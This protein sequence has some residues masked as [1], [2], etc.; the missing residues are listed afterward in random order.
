MLSQCSFHLY[1]PLVVAAP[2][3]NLRK[4]S[5]KSQRIYKFDFNSIPNVTYYVHMDNRT[6]ISNNLLNFDCV[7]ET[8]RKDTHQT[9]Q[10][11]D[12]QNRSNLLDT[13]MFCSAVF[14][15]KNISLL[16]A[17][18]IQTANPIQ[19]AKQLSQATQPANNELSTAHLVCIKY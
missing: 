2:W 5:P 10:S 8:R 19:I 15:F 16:S 13:K 6:C 14:N 17:W 3:I 4:P 9:K 7:H 18:V 12:T 1:C 11:M